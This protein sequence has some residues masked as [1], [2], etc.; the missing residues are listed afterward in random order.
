M[1][2]R[3]MIPVLLLISAFVMCAACTPGR[4]SS[5]K[6]VLVRVPGDNAGG[7]AVP[8]RAELTVEERAQVDYYYELLKETAP[9]FCA[10]PRKL[11]RETVT[12][13]DDCFSVS[14]TFYLGGYGFPYQYKLKTGPDCPEGYWTATE[15]GLCGQIPDR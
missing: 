12:K 15:D 3:F 1:K 5:Q 6:R 9:D 8:E 2:K 13:T 7:V 11:I 10:I 4:P 14:Y